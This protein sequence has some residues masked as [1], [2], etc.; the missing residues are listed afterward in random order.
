MSGAEDFFKLPQL[1]LKFAGFVLEYEQSWRGYL[2]RIWA[3]INYISLAIFWMFSLHFVFYNIQEVLITPD[4]VGL[5]L[6]AFFLLVKLGS[7][8][9]YRGQNKEMIEMMIEMAKA[10]LIL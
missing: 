6:S 2:L 4:I 3:A 1:Y 9:N 10:G 5:T 8:Y 7:F